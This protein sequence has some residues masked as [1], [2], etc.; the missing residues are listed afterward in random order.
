MVDLSNPVQDWV[1]ESTNQ[2]QLTMDWFAGHSNDNPCPI[3]LYIGWV[4]M[5][6]CKSR[7]RYFIC[8]VIVIIAT[9]AAHL[10]AVSGSYEGRQTII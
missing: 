6:P 8:V 1:A 4:R 9:V 7:S 10:V 3:K 2:S 5:F